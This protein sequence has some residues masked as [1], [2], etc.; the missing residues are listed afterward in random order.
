MRFGSVRE[1]Q[2]MTQATLLMGELRTPKNAFQEAPGSI[3][4]D[5]VASKL[6]FK[7]G[8]VPGSV[9]MDQFVPMILDLYGPKWFGTG[10]MSLYFTQATVHEKVRAE[11]EQGDKRLS[12]RMF[13]EGEALICTG[14]ASAAAPDGDSEMQN[15]MRGLRPTGE[16]RILKD[17]RVGDETHDNP[18]SV[19]KEALTKALENITE[20][21]D[22]YR[23]HD[24]LPPSHVIKLAHQTRPAVHAKITP[25]AVG[26]FGA[27]EV[28]QYK[29]PLYAGQDYVADT[30]VLKLSDSPKTEAIWYDVMIREPGS[31]EV[32]GGVIFMIRYMK[33]S[34][35]LWTS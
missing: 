19:S 11:V 23:D 9:H 13:N 25:G 22:I 28:R 15:R 21:L 6:G 20:P 14:T 31:I 34:S 32:L 5:A 35:P 12:L 1:K 7:G 30:K 26:L 10:D 8:T 18:L 4:N 17:V 24:V 29:G 2:I 16:L 33:A 27:L 3:H